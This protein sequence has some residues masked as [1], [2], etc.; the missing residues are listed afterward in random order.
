MV[1]QLEGPLQSRRYRRQVF[2]LLIR[3]I[4]W[5]RKWQ[6]TPVFWPEESN[7]Q[8]SLISS[9]KGCKELDTT[10]QTSEQGLD[11]CFL[12]FEFMFEFKSEKL[13]EKLRN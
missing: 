8:R 13:S 7:G 6:P 5:R 11:T 9:P 1:Q 4:P 2:S 10:E 3:K 12:V